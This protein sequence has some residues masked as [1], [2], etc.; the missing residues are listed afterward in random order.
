MD[1]TRRLLRGPLGGWSRTGPGTAAPAAWRL[2]R[3]TWSRLSLLLL[4]RLKVR[5]DMNTEDP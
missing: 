4:K 5:H 1:R 3:T 2:R